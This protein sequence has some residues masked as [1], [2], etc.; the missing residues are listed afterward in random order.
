MYSTIDSWHWQLISQAILQQYKVNQYL[1]AHVGALHFWVYHYPY[2]H[3]E[4]WKRFPA[5]K[6][7][8]L[9]LNHQSI[10]HI[11][12]RAILPVVLVLQ[13]YPKRHFCSCILTPPGLW[14]L[15]GP[16]YII[17]TKQLLVEWTVLFWERS[18]TPP[19]N[20]TYSYQKMIDVFFLNNHSISGFKCH[21][22]SLCYFLGGPSKNFLGFHYLDVP[23][24]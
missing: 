3:P 24:S 22:C 11:G 21:T 8:Y 17:K 20:P 6:K 1:L 10:F 15:Y 13:S 2:N 18:H 19:K 16:L 5:S 12:L 7:N 4:N 9:D 14:V 23:G